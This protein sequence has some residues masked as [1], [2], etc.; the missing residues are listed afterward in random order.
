MRDLHRFDDIT[1]QERHRQSRGA[2]DKNKSESLRLASDVRVMKKIQISCKMFVIFL[3]SD[4]GTIA[5]PPP[6]MQANLQKNLVDDR[7]EQAQNTA[8]AVFCVMKIFFPASAHMRR[9]AQGALPLDPARGIMPLDPLLLY[10]IL[11]RALR[12]C[13]QHSAHFYYKKYGG[14]GA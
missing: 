1:P 8:S 9:S 5:Q 3:F 12:L 7:P 10:I 4:E 2:L 14:V 13:P 11:R 6:E